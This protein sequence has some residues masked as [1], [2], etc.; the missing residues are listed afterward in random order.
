M[1]KAG[2]VAAGIDEMFRRVFWKSQFLAKE[3]Q[4]FWTEVKSTEPKGLSIQ[5]WRDWGLKRGMSVGQFYNMIHGL[6]G[7]GMLERR[8]TEWHI[9][10][11][12]LNELE[13]LTI[14]YAQQAGY[15][16]SHS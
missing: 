7:A 9:S 15:Q 14:L 12:F 16:R 6:V 3:A 2:V 10:S 13:Q 5:A 1:F 8:K 4:T 11:G